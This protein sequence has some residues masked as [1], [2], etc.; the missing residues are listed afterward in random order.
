ML[1]STL[2]RLL[3]LVTCAVACAAALPALAQTKPWPQE[4]LIKWLVGVPPAGTADPLTRA[5][6]A[7]LSKRIGQSI[8]IEN[9]PGANQAIARTETARAPADG[10]T[11]LTVAGPTLYAKPVPDIGSGLAPVIRLAVQPMVLAG[12]ATRTTTDL[13]ALLAAIKADP[14]AWSYATAG[15]ASSQHLVGEEINL[16]AGTKMVHV[17]YRGGGAALNDAISGAVPLII[18]GAGPIIPQ[19]KSGIL[20]AYAVTTKERLGLLP[21]VPT[22]AE[23]GFPGIDSAQWFG[24]AVHQDTPQEIVARLNKEMLDILKQPDVVKLLDTFGAV[25]AGGTP[26]EWGRFYAQEYQSRRAL[27]EKVGIPIN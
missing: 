2:R 19:V 4:R 1:A 9:K 24:V 12:S 7:E 13:K 3:A 20:R 17:P 11:I 27:A 15:T 26:A 8:V 16:L 5:V 10:Y 22:L 23:Q 21:G 6:A 14:A 25:A 18:I